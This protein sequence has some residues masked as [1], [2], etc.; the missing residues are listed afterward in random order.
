MGKSLFDLATDTAL[1]SVPVPSEKR[2]RTCGEIENDLEQAEMMK[3]AIHTQLE[4][5]NS[6]ES[7]LCTALRT[8]G[9]LTNDEQ[10]ADR[11][12]GILDEVYSDLAQQSFIADNQAIARQRLEDMG[13]KYREKVRK[14]VNAQMSGYGKIE[15]ALRDVLVAVSEMDGLQDWDDPD[16]WP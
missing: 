1:P 13:A 10:W 16:T 7:I 4:E 11:C 5:G 2:G 14:A 6:P 3:R 9:L 12:M 15:K 8:I